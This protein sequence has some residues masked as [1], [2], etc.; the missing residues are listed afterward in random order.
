[1]HH[2]FFADKRPH[3]GMTYSDYFEK[4][5]IK[6]ETIDPTN[7]IGEE[8]ERS[9]YRKLNF[10][11][12]SRIHK[13]YLVDPVLCDMIKNISKPQLWMVITEDWCGD[14]SQN[15][16][17]IAMMSKFNPLIN[18]RIILRDQNTDIMDLYLTD[19]IS[20]SIPKLVAFDEHGEEIFQWGPRPR[21]AQELVNKLKSEGKTHDE[22]IEQL[23]L[24]YGRNRGKAIES[25]FKEILGSK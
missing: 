18:L 5:R 14:S 17:Y 10:Q 13:T 3:N 25:E 2:Q 15:F 1:M 7:L 11:R 23:H 9:E 24:W 12:S 8:K 20:R 22:F 21:E 6:V 19:G 16:P 4:F